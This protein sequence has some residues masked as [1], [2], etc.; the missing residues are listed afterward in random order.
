MMR[1]SSKFLDFRRDY[2]IL[3]AIKHTCVSLVPEDYVWEI[4]LLN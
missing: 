1:T 4:I 2:G 3:V